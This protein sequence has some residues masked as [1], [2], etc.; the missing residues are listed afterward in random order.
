MIAARVFRASPLDALVAGA[1]FV[2]AAIVVAALALA[3]SGGAGPGARAGLAVLL[4]VA[5]SWGAN[6]VSHIHLHGPLFRDGRANRAFS[7]FLSVLLAVPQSWWKRRHLEHHGLCSARG[8]ASH[9]D[10]RGRGLL[11]F[12][13]WLAFV[14]PFAIASPVAMA[15]VYAPSVAL[16]LLLCAN[17]GRQEHRAGAAGVDTRG[18]LYNRF[19]FNDGFHAAHHRAPEAHWT[20]LPARASSDDVVSALPPILRAFEE[21]PALR[22]RVAA[23]VIDA[24]E[25]AALGLK[26]LRRYLL[27]THARGW[28]RLLSGAD[29]AAI[30]SVTII[31]GGLYPR[32]ALI[33]ARLLPHARLTVLDAVPA[34]L[35]RARVFLAPLMDAA[36]PR[37]RLAAGVFD[38]AAPTCDADLL[39]VPLA[40]RGDR[41]RLYAAPPAPRVAVHD[42]IWRARGDRGV[43]VSFLLFKRLNLVT[44]PAA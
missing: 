3:A 21:L 12:G 32:T 39:V 28:R 23:A 37:V 33:L 36:S 5:M 22:N 8:C 16:G 31:G 2:H 20:T 29:V 7:L 26:P 15:T 38:P 9:A 44:S 1:A 30:R 4:A 24:L 10:L 43:V 17:Q 41:A 13:V 11:E 40:F 18:R 27:E 25:R 42:W 6:T 34:H 14:V 19:W 35:D